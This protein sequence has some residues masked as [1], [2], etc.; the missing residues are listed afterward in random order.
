MAKHQPSSMLPSSSS[1]GVRIMRMLSSKRARR[2]FIG[3]AAEISV[4]LSVCL[5]MCTLLLPPATEAV[6]D[7]LLEHAL[8]SNGSAVR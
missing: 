5:L 7:A 1:E 3:R 4:L 2:R 6:Q 8:R